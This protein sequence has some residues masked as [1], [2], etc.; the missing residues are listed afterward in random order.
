MSWLSGALFRLVE[1]E[2]RSF[3]ELN[4]R[5]FLAALASVPVA[6]FNFVADGAPPPDVSIPP[7]ENYQ[8]HAGDIPQHGGASRG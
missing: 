3:A 7:T 6:Q 8:T 1:Q 5:E 2:R 4:Y